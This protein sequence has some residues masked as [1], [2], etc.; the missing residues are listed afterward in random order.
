MALEQL[1]ML[2]GQTTLVERVKYQL[3]VGSPFLFVTGD[4]G[5]GKTVFCEKLSS[6][7]EEKYRC[8]F[9]PCN[10]KLTLRNLRELIFQQ[11]S[12]QTIFNQ[13]D[14]LVGTIQRIDFGG[15]QVVIVIDNIDEADE[16]FLL[17]LAEIHQVYNNNKQVFHI[18]LTSTKEWAQARIRS[19]NDAGINP[20]EIEIPSLSKQDKII[21]LEYYYKVYGVRY[22]PENIALITPFA[23]LTTPEDVRKYAENSFK[24]NMDKIMEKQKEHENKAT[25]TQDEKAPRKD[26]NLKNNNA[27]TKSS[28]LPLILAIAALVAVVIG[29]AFYFSKKNPETSDITSTVAGD[30]ATEKAIAV[31][32]E[33]FKVENED[34]NDKPIVIDKDKKDNLAKISLNDEAVQSIN[35][36]INKQ[37]DTSKVQEVKENESSNSSTNEEKVE[38]KVGDDKASLD[39]TNKAKDL[40]ANNTNKV[41]NEKVAANDTTISDKNVTDTKKVETKVDSKVNNQSEA[42]A[43]LENTNQKV[44]PKST[45]TS[46]VTTKETTK[47]ATPKEEQQKVESKNVESSKA[48][49]EKVETTSTKQNEKSSFNEL[50]DKYYTVQIASNPKKAAIEKIVKNVSGKVWIEYRASKKDYIALWGEFKT[51]KEAT[52]EIKT[53]PQSIQK[54]GPWAKKIGSVK[55]ELK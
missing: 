49:E 37:N 39:K 40:E 11:I 53:L 32:P 18:V 44:A 45:D 14:R 6:A 34:L 42:P 22:Q 47:V 50:D 9:V 25:Q 35:D 21:E 2:P 24:Q 38:V 28:K 12:P 1:P 3:A 33:E 15:K 19:L 41:A 7:I 23:K 52:Q 46:K 54:S 36:E 13:D 10:K 29:S 8:A 20:V 5:S 55:A 30:K 27:K 16:K 4:S 43:I 48:K 26:I 31:E 17:E 51:N